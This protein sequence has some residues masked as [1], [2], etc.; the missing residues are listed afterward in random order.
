MQFAGQRTDIDLTPIESQ[1][2][3]IFLK[4]PD[5]LPNPEV[6]LVTGI[7]PQKH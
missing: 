4:N 3:F 2:I 5:I 7:T 6:V 1:I